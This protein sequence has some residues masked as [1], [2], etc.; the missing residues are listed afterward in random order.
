M[1]GRLIKNQNFLAGIA[2]SLVGIFMLVD[3]IRFGRFINGNVGADFFPKMVSTAL[4]LV[5]ISLLSS[6]LTQ[7]KKE[8][9]VANG[10]VTGQIKGNV[11]EFLGTIAVLILYILLLEPLGFIIATIPFCF[12]LILLISPKD[13]RNYLLFAAISVGV[14]IVAYLLF[15]KVFYV[16][17]PQGILG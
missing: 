15:V 16:M 10:G 6:G 3:A 11:P 12:S 5:G 4:L 9:S 8:P 14:A 2:L 13:K 17:L 1:A 7:V